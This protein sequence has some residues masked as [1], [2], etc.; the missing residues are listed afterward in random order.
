[1]LEIPTLETERLRL[2][3][4]REE[5]IAF[6]TRIYADPQV[7]RYIGNG[8]TMDAHATWRSCATILGHWLLRGYGQWVAEEK[9]TGATLGRVGLYH[10]EG[11]PG[12]EVGW[13][14]APE[15]W[16]K[17]Y[18]TEGARAALRYAFDVV[19]ADRVISVIQPENIASRRVAEKLGGTMEQTTTLVGKDVLVYAY[20]GAPPVG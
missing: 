12:L 14:L 15:Y 6:F 17:G 18:A 9:A 3:G 16:G 10:P 13:T 20:R 11:W 7:V 1:V 5:D 2:R 19:G 8:Q 4:L